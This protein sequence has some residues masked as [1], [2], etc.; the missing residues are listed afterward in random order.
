MEDDI[1][2]IPLGNVSDLDGLESQVSV[3]LI[4]ATMADRFLRRGGERQDYLPV[5]V[6]SE[7]LDVPDIVFDSVLL[8]PETLALQEFSEGLPMSQDGVE[9]AV[10][11]YCH[12]LTRG[13]D[14]DITS[15]MRA[16]L[17]GSRSINPFVRINAISSISRLFNRRSAALSSRLE[18][19]RNAC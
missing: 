19:F 8:E 1:E 2:P 7:I 5:S 9:N 18:W 11:E 15:S 6:F 10:L 3:A 14:I 17:A 12:S 4:F 16:L 13:E